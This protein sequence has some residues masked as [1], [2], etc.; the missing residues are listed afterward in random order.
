MRVTM[1]KCTVY[2][3]SKKSTL[4]WR[5]AMCSSVTPDCLI[6]LF[7]GPC[8]SYRQ[9]YIRE[10]NIHPSQQKAGVSDKER[11]SRKKR[12][13]RQARVDE[14][15]AKNVEETDMK[16]WSVKPDSVMRLGKNEG[17]KL[18]LFLGQGH[19]TIG[20]EVV[21]SVLTPYVGHSTFLKNSHT[22]PWFP[23]QTELGEKQNRMGPVFTR[24]S[25]FILSVIGFYCC[26][27][28]YS[29]STSLYCNSVETIWPLSKKLSLVKKKK[30]GLA[31]T[32]EQKLQS[33][34]P[35]KLDVGLG[36]PS[37]I[38]RAR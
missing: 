34:P 24:L 31:K 13:D 4:P 19:I 30:F 17:R 32:S 29:L 11:K 22:S 3:C 7:Q 1:I 26:H 28:L 18:E 23:G 10:N 37:I 38:R 16:T 14:V 6:L 15:T 20:N 25:H 36:M 27:R 21:F 12:Q 8:S 9:L 35:V 2:S 5:A 33:F